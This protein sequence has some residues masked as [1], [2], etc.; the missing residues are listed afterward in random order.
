M[1]PAI[2]LVVGVGAAFVP[3]NCTAN[4]GTAH[5][6]SQH[7]GVV[8]GG[9]FAIVLAAIALVRARKVG[10][11]GPGVFAL[12][13]AGVGAA[14]IAVGVV[15]LQRVP[16][17]GD[18]ID[19]DDSVRK[20]FEAMRDDH[21]NL[22]PG[23]ADATHEELATIRALARGFARGL[24]RYQDISGLQRTSGDDGAVIATGTARYE[25]GSP[26]FE[27]IF[28][29]VD[30]TALLSHIKLTIPPD[31]LPPA[32]DAEKAARQFAAVV[33][34]G[35]LDRVHDDLDPRIQ[36]PDT[37]DKMVASAPPLVASPLAIDVTSHTTCDDGQCFEL[38]IHLKDGSTARV[39]VTES[40]TFG[41][42]LASS[43]KIG[44]D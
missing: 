23:A 36:I 6:T 40:S 30:G 24:G 11:G 18:A 10:F 20:V 21:V 34:A 13:V 35:A 16:S 22:L 43:F 4:V 37:L 7:G 5:Y 1:L 41:I 2:G 19:L 31:Q 29:V 44:D 32:A 14:L 42:W 39:R 25:R 17:A 27:L 26:R 9:L 3:M 33:A 38:H 28:R 8:V 15:V 12:V